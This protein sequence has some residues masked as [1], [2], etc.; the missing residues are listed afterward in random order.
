MWLCRNTHENFPKVITQVINGSVDSSSDHFPGFST[1]GDRGC[2]RDGQYLLSNTT[3]LEL[4][5]NQMMQDETYVI[6]LVVRKGE[7]KGHTNQT[8]ELG[9]ENLPKLTIR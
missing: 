6:V 1:T 4:K 9:P 8:L 2:Y 3:F 5:T 7:R